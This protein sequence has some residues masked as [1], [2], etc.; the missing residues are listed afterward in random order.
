MAEKAEEIQSVFQTVE[1]FEGHI[2]G[3]RFLCE[4]KR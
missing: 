2:K 1:D 3:F 4:D